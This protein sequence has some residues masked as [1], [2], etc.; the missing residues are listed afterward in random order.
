[1]A[2]QVGYGSFLNGRQVF[3]RTCSITV[4]DPL[5]RL[6]TFGANDTFCN[7]VIAQKAD[8]DV[9]SEDRRVFVQAVGCHVTPGT[10]LS[11][12]INDETAH[13]GF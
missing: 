4:W 10:M 8:P 9:G 13:F 3:Y 2:G 12:K 5:V 11:F 6:P 7:L 1:M